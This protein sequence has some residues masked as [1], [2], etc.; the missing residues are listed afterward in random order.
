[1]FLYR[2]EHLFRFE[3]GDQRGGRTET[4]RNSR[5]TGVARAE[6]QRGRSTNDVVLRDLPSV[7][8]ETVRNNQQFLHEVH[9]PFGSSGCARRIEEQ[10]NV[11]AF[12]EHGI[13]LGDRKS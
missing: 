6:S 8:T 2:V 3:P 4:E 1:M 7:L 11:L 9:G 5:V 13:D 10:T 12:A